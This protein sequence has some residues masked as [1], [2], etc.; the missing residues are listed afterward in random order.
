MFTNVAPEATGFI[1]PEEASEKSYVRTTINHDAI[2]KT[3][4]LLGTQ[5]E[6]H[7]I[8]R[9]NPFSGV[10]VSHDSYETQ[11]PIVGEIH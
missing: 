5:V 10:E 11:K 9:V 4:V 3:P 8:S 2:V 7:E 1:T 6:K